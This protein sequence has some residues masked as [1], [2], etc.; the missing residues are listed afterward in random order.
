MD[1][2][3]LVVSMVGM[4]CAWQIVFMHVHDD[5][6]FVKRVHIFCVCN[7]WNDGMRNFFG[8]MDDVWLD[9][10]DRPIDRKHDWDLLGL[11]DGSSVLSVDRR[12]SNEVTYMS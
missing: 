3:L 8:W 5:L 4:C 9:A 10:T 6:I 1:C 11:T 7:V 12:T 2:S